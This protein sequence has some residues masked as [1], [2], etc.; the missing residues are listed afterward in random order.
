MGSGPRGGRLSQGFA[1][2]LEEVLRLKREEG[3]GAWQTAAIF[4]M[5]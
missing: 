4:T 5:R 1:P 3:G 2:T